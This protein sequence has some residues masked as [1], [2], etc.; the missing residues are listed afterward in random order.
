MASVRV[1]TVPAGSST[2][3]E[4]SPPVTVMV[5][6]GL[7]GSSEVQLTVNSTSAAASI[8]AW[9]PSRSFSTVNEPGALVTVLV[10]WRA[11]LVP[12]WTVKVAVLP[13]SETVTPSAGA[14]V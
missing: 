13:S 6:E 5:P 12:G 10:S 3:S 11:T 1:T 7:S 14:Q 2:G 9:S 4:V 8:A